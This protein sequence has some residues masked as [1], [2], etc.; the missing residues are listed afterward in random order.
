MCSSFV[1]FLLSKLHIYK[2]STVCSEQTLR[3]AVCEEYTVLFPLLL[4]SLECHR[5]HST[6]S[7][8]PNKDAS[9]LYRPP[10]IKNI[11]NAANPICDG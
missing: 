8:F 7:Y 9:T 5:L 1:A 11:A 2:K 10:P 4:F 6:T 3:S